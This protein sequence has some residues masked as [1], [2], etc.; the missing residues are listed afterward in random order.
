MEFEIND[1]PFVSV[2][3]DTNP[4]EVIKAY[5]ARH[6]NHFQMMYGM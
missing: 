2:E 4:K 5:N 6:A 3:Q 1:D